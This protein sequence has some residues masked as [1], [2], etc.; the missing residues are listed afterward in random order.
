MVFVICAW[1]N[2][3]VNNRRAG[4]LRRRRA[5]YDVIVIWNERMLFTIVSKQTAYTFICIELLISVHDDRHFSGD[6]FITVGPTAM[7]FFE[8]NKSCQW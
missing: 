3:L 7:N 2:V 4:D 1:I 6:D 5:H 8:M